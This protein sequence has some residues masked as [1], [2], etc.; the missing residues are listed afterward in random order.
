MPA[1]TMKAIAASTLKMARIL[2]AID[3]GHVSGREVA[4]RSMG[5]DLYR[6]SDCDRSES[7]WQ[8]NYGARRAE[9]R[10]GW[11]PCPLC[12]R[13]RECRV[14]STEYG[15]TSGPYTPPSI[16]AG[17]SVLGTVY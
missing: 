2:P 16:A 3:M 7:G 4:H 5:V 1:T 14:R 8:G 11:G 12:R 17:Y 9:R 10:K 6:S 15:V 13:R